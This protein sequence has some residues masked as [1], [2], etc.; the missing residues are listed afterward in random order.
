MPNKSYRGA[1]APLSPQESQIKT[2][3]EQHIF[4][5]AHTIGPRH[6]EK[7]HALEKA[8]TYIKTQL[9]AYGHTVL[10]HDYVLENITCENII[11]EIKGNEKPEDIII[12][13]AHYDSV[14]PDCP[15]ANDNGSGVAALLILARLFSQKTF[16]KT[17][18]FAFFVN[19]EPPFFYTKKMGSYIYAK[20]LK[21]KK[22]RVKAMISVET[23]GYYSEEKNSQ[24]YPFPFGLFYPNQGN[25]VGFVG[26]L[27]SRK[28]LIKAIS[29]FRQCTA[30]PSEGGALPRWIPGVGWSDQLSFWRMGYP[31]MMIT[32]TAPF[33][34]PYYH[35]NEDTADKINYIYT[36]RVVQG[37]QR[38]VEELAK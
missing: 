28:L 26:N 24:V 16:P 17:V 31:A 38:M 19:E 36:A 32:D 20:S 25:F 12:L 10:I 1:F 9:Q 14:M 34:Y 35:T 7:P 5:L 27:S 4:Q 18:R 11:V 33:R 22:E 37:I 15:G 21:Q 29:I 6:L 3:L 23:I 2:E 30:F 8:A 13:G